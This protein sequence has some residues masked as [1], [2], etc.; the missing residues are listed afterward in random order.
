MS[1]F[2]REEMTSQN[3]LANFSMN[4]TISSSKSR[5]NADKVREDTHNFPPLAKPMGESS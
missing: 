3:C 4:L 2:C 5:L 1:K